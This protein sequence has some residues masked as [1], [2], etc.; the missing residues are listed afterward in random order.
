MGLETVSIL[1]I[2]QGAR[3]PVARIGLGIAGL[4]IAGC[5]GM[6]HS[7]DAQGESDYVGAGHGMDHVASKK[8][9]VEHDGH[10]SMQS[11]HGHVGMHHGVLEIPA[12][13]AVPK[14]NLSV[15]PDSVRG[16]NVN[17]AVENFAFAPERVNQASLTTEGHGHLFIDGEKMTRLYGSWYYIPALPAG[18]H[19]IR[20]ELNANGHEILQSDGKPIAATV[21]V[22]VP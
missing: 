10:G 4:A 15:E 20:V 2:G 11:G 22:T 8:V 18:E 5:A 1:S 6:T 12:G 13:Q 16:W 7:M 19:E 9:G 3:R 21:M 17:A 14:L